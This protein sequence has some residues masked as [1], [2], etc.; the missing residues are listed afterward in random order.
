MSD[1]LVASIPLSLG[2]YIA[3]LTGVINMPASLIFDP[4]SFYFGILPILS[5]IQQFSLR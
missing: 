2:R 5:E 3:V 1:F 4:D